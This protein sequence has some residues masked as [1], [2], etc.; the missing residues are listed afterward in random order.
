[1]RPGSKTT[2]F[3]QKIKAISVIEIS[4][5]LGATRRRAIR[6]LDVTVVAPRSAL[7]DFS[8]LLLAAP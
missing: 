3:T 6:D 5:W 2:S 8:P 4:T 7:W 1:M